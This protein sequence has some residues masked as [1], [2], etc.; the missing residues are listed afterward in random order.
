MTSRRLSRL[1]ACLLAIAAAILLFT[2]APSPAATAPD[3][4]GRFS[5]TYLID[6]T[7]VAQSLQIEVE[8]QHGRRFKV[9][10][11]ALNEPEY[12]GRG[13]LARDGTTAKLVTHATGRRHLILM[14]NVGGGGTELDGTFIGKRPGHASTTGTF[15]V[16]R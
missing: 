6:G 15:S 16:S 11:F 7:S 8:K 1:R 13:R 2:T 3:L 5:G 9:S 14:A 4:T 12:M 10:V